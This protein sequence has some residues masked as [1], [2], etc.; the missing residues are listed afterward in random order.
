M[1]GSA[2]TVAAVLAE[3]H[4]DGMSLG[5]ALIAAVAALGS[6]DRESR[7]IPPTQL[8]V[9]VLDRARPGRT[10]KRIV[11]AQLA[12]LVPDAP[13]PVEPPPGDDAGTASP[14]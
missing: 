14:E 8:E 1:G 5:D 13:E 7:S 9:A 3:R 2:D 12:S 10:F 11:G 4:Q 6:Q